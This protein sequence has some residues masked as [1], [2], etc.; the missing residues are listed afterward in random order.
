LAGVMYLVML[1]IC[2]LHASILEYFSRWNSLSLG[3]D[4]RALV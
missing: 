2:L 4:I 3:D 1:S